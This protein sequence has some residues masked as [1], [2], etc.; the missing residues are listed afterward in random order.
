MAVSVAP[1]QRI[2]LLGTVELLHDHLTTSLCQTVFQQTRTTERERQWSL[3]ALASFWTEVILRAPQSLTQALQEA[4]LGNNSGWPPV[5]ASPE[6]FFQRCQS[7]NWRFFAKLHEAF[8]AQVLPQAQPCYASPVHTLREHFQ[9][10]WIVD[11]SRLDAVAKRLKLLWDIRAQVLPGCLTA[12][13]DLYR[14]IVRHLAFHADAAAGELPRA[15][16]ALEQVSK[17]TL[18]VGDRLYGV[19][20][21]FAALSERGIFGLCRRNGRQSWR[22]LRELSKSFIAGGTAWDTLI[23]IKGTKDIPT[24]TL[25]WIK[26][27][28]GG[29]SWEMLT[30]VLEPERLSI[31]DA[32]GLYPWRWKVERLFFDL[33]EVLNLHRFY[34]SSPNGVAMQ[35]YAAALV[36]TAFRVAQGHTAQ[37]IGTQPEEIS[38]A[39]FFPRMAAAAIGLT[40]SELAFIEIQKANPGID[41][42]KP[43]WHRC[44]FAWATFEHVRVESR[45]GRRRKRRFCTSRKQWKSFTHIPGGKKLT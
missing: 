30:N 35:V 37:A 6:A 24:Q 33:K 21:F 1:D 20:T 9:E 41:L 22:W 2:A 42:Q 29:E 13:Y 19:G 23:E 28:K 25:R 8:V 14:G 5:Q 10:V 39:K 12:L 36:H 17:G 34:T 40:W 18:L 31:R 7:L 45:N 3:E 32:L 15:I 38:P 27:R 26:W 44:A 16:A 43:D 11:G 4:A